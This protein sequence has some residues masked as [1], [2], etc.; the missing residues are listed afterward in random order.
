MAQHLAPLL[1]QRGELTRDLVLSRHADSQHLL[2][3]LWGRRSTQGRQSKSDA[4]RILRLAHPMVF[5]H[6]KE[7]FD[8]VG[9]DRQ[10]DVIEPKRLGDVKLVRKISAYPKLILYLSPKSLITPSTY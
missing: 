5:G 7:R 2:G 6:P 3:L 10:A 4:S 8:R 9:A 1:G